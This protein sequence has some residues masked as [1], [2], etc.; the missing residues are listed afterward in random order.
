MLFKLNHPHLVKLGSQKPPL[1]F[2]PYQDEYMQVLEGRLCVEVEGLETVLTPDHGEFTVKAWSHHRLYPPPAHGAES[3][4][5][6][7]SGAETNEA[8]RLDNVFFSNWYGYQDD[9]VLNGKEFDLIQVLSMFDAGSSYLSW[10]WWVPFGRYASIAFSIGVGR[11]IGGLLG[12]QPF[13]RK[14]SVDWDTA[15][16][17]MQ[18]SIFQRRF[19]CLSKDE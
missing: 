1:H 16:E 10:P 18:Q 15:C 3:C 5:F 6:I 11:W 14:W 13:Y 8:F 4:R 12:Y 9:V 2:H 17:R 7:L 19:A